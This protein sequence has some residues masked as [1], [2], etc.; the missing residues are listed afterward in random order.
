MIASPCAPQYDYR[1]TNFIA[2]PE[3]CIALVLPEHRSRLTTGGCF[4][5]SIN[6]SPDENLISI[7]CVEVI[8]D[9]LAP[10]VPPETPDLEVNVYVDDVLIRTYSA[11]FGYGGI[12]DLRAQMEYD[13]ANPPPPPV[14]PL[15]IEMLPI[16]DDIFDLRELP[17]EDELLM[18][19]LEPFA[20]QNLSGGSGGPTTSE[21]LESIRTGPE[22]TIF[23][24]STTELEDGSP[25]DPPASKR[26]QQWDGVEWISYCNLAAGECPLEGT[27]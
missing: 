8:P 4:F 20:K 7:E 26:V 6:Q 17:E 19:G 25:T 23:I 3:D 18:K 11:I 2:G 13:I 1:P 5:R 27:C 24:L 22:R 10:P 16:N 12:A 21:G 9:P 15:P 14:V